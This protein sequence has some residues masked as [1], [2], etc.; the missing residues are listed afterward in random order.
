MTH[1]F[2]FAAGILGACLALP[3]A[4]QD[5]ITREVLQE[6]LVSGDDGLTVVVS[7]LTVAP[8]ARIP[9]HTHPGD[10]H[11]VVLQGGSA[12]MPNGAAMTMTPM[13][14][15]FFEAGSVHGGVVNTGDTPIEILTTHVL[16]AGEAFQS[17][18][19]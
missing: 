3:V 14:T 16:R 9:L 18:A 5:G 10:E 11:A 1:W 17:P 8:G 6:R 2:P 12:Q 15:L 13:M 4:A 7:R 19:E